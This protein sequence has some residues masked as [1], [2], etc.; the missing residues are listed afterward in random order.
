MA[1]YSIQ[2]LLTEVL[3]KNGSDLHLTANMPAAIRIDGRLNFINYQIG[4]ASC[5]ERV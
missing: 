3:K 1:V 4:R 2:V 5:R